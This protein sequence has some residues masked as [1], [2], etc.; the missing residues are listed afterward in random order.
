MTI[1]NEKEYAKDLYE[2]QRDPSLQAKAYTVWELTIL[3]KYLRQELK[4]SES[5]IKTNIIKFCNLNYPGFDADVEY[6]RIN[7]VVRDCY[8]TDLRQSLPVPITKKEWNDIQKGSTEKRQ[9][10]LFVI[11]AVAKF[12]RLNPIV[13]TEDETEKEYTDNRLRCFEKESDLYKLM[14]MKLKNDRF[15]YLPYSEFG[16]LGLNLIEIPN[17]NKFK[18]ILNYGEID[19]KEEDIL[20]KIEDFNKLPEYFLA[21]QEDKRI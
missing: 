20:I 9:K 10:L 6:D 4:Q 7:K 15:K 16:K 1:Y 18:R 3:A 12:N 14:K 11:L 13:Y 21:L 8:K 5:E 2:R 19:A 17:S